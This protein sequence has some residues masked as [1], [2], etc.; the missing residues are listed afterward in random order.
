[1]IVRRRPERIR[2]WPSEKVK[3]IGSDVTG[4][5]LRH[6]FFV[7]SFS[8]ALGTGNGAGQRAMNPVYQAQL[9]DA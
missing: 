4:S 6:A 1:M 5:G 9:R 7:R 3:G 2:P 8:R